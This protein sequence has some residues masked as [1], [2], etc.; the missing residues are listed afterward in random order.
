[1]STAVMCMEMRRLS[2]SLP[3]GLRPHTGMREHNPNIRMLIPCRPSMK[4][5]MRVSA[6][7]RSRR[8]YPAGDFCWGGILRPHETY[9]DFKNLNSQKPYTE[10]VRKESYRMAKTL[11]EQLKEVTVVVADSGDFE[12]I[13]KF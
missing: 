10:S 3:L 6:P 4:V 13:E 9:R 2:A 11:L 5:A 1:M 8:L 12:S 7:P